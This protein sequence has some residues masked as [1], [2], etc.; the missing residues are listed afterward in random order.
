MAAVK[1]KQVRILIITLGIIFMIWQFSTYQARDIPEE[2]YVST[3]TINVHEDDDLLSFSVMDSELSELV[4]LPGGGVQPRAY[5]PLARNLAEEGFTVHIVK[6]PYRMP[7]WGYDKILD[8]F[9]WENGRFVLG[10]HSQGAKMAAQ[11]AYEHPE[12]P[13]ALF[14]IATTHPR[15]IDMSHMSMRT[16]KIL[17]DRD[18]LVESAD[19][20]VNI[21]KLPIGSSLLTIEG[22]NHS[23]F[24]HMGH[25]LMDGTPAISREEQQRKT[26]EIL[27]D[28]FAGL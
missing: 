18:G 15:D 16:V 28:A 20:A 6:M 22:A 9:D 7:V 26:V 2:D 13:A 27:V 3:D 17:G 8:L 10:G 19:V 21:P 24:G 14:L 11:F 23:Q 25:L 4:F 1:R 5:V 12:L